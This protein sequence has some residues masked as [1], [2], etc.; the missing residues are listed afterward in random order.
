MAH[1]TLE[2]PTDH[3]FTSIV[4][5]TQL[6]ALRK[7][8]SSGLKFYSIK[9]L[10]SICNLQY[11]RS[12]QRDGSTSPPGS[13][14]RNAEESALAIAVW[15]LLPFSLTGVTG[16][17]REAY[18][19]FGR[20]VHPDSCRKRRSNILFGCVEFRQ[21]GALLFEQGHYFHLRVFLMNPT[22]T[23]RKRQGPRNQTRIN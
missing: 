16:N 4:Q 10:F 1:L 6:R 12:L 14:D 3:F 21:G 19:N 7:W 17:G 9:H 11:L 13:A 23:A 18:I 22:T 15:H 5:K 2:R 20:P 8:K